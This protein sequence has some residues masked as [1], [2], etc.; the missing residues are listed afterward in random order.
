M[1][2]LEEARQIIN[3]VDK[4]MARLFEKRMNAVKMV[5]EY[6]QAHGMA[7]LDATREK[8]VLERN[9]QYIT[10]ENITSFYVRFLQSAMDVSKQYQHK[11]LEGMKIA[12]SGV[13]G[14]F[15][16]IAAGR[17][18]PDGQLMSFGDFESA[19]QAVVDGHCDCCVL[20]IENSYAG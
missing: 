2:H 9:A 7:V 17:I 19:Y 20:P 8:I 5:A 13:E 11:L 1:D 4:E 18:F 15:A 16:S 14:A 12:Y 3:E 6:K 10:D